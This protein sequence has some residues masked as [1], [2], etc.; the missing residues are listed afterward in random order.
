MALAFYKSK[1]DF[2]CLLLCLI[3]F[4]L[5]LDLHKKSALD[6]Y[7]CTPSHRT[8]KS[9][10]VPATVELYRKLGLSYESDHR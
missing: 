9:V 6:L 5:A 4:D 7:L 2:L 1:F 3:A 10:G 8:G